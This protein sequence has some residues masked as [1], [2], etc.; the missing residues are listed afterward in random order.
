MM[1]WTRLALTGRLYDFLYLPGF[2]PAT[3]DEPDAVEWQRG[4]MCGCASRGLRDL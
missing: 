1:S 3:D 4:S 2:L